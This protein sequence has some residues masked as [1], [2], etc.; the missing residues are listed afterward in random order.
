[1]AR[2]LPT[3]SI[4]RMLSAP[5]EVQGP[6]NPYLPSQKELNALTIPKHMKPI[7]VIG[8]AHS[9]DLALL[10]I[11]VPTCRYPDR[12][13]AGVRYGLAHNARVD[14]KTQFRPLFSRG[15]C[16]AK[17]WWGKHEPGHPFA[18]RGVVR[19]KVSAHP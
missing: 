12:F 17:M 18:A 8:V 11:S 15:F 13:I 1:M 10:G 4:Y 6:H 9:I 7:D 5:T 14:V 2:N 16:L 3:G 19:G